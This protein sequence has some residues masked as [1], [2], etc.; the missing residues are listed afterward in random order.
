VRGAG[1]GLAST[2]CCLLTAICCAP[3]RVTPP[4]L[5]DLPGCLQLRY[6]VLQ[7]LAEE[8]QAESGPGPEPQP[9][10]ESR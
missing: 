4:S 1:L 6:A 9:R 3:A 5:L 8:Q 2:L 7:L 10:T